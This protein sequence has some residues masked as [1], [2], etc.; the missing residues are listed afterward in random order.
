MDFALSYSYSN[1][2]AMDI[3]KLPDGTVTE[4]LQDLNASIHYG[5]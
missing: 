5:K 1:R 2:S 4:L 3:H